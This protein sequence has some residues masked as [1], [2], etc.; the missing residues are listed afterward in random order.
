MFYSYT[1]VCYALYP[2]VF[3]VATQFNAIF[4]AQ[5]TESTSLSLL[6]MWLARRIHSFLTLLSTQLYAV[7][8]SAALRDALEASVFFATSMGR[9]GA[10][11]APQLGPIFEPRMLA[12]V[13]KYWKDGSQQ[14]SETLSTCRQA[15]VNFPL[16]AIISTPSTT[17][18][19]TT[20]S[21]ATDLVDG[22][23]PPPR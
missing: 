21:S 22:V 2:S 13:T 4:R 7:E 11:I 14:L 20:A 12:L 23:M 8:D 16:V 5:T 18:D 3:E 6:S 17:T 1:F 9:L 19:G 15:Q 10:D